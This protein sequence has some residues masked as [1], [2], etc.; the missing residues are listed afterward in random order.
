MTEKRGCFMK[1]R[2]VK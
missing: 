2:V 1:H